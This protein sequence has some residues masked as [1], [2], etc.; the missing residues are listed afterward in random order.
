MARRRRIETLAGLTAT[1]FLLLL[2]VAVWLL[3]VAALV[4][5][6]VLLVMWLH[7]LFATRGLPHVAGRNAFSITHEEALEKQTHEARLHS[8]KNDLREVELRG[9]RLARTNGGKF[10][11]RSALGKELNIRV[12]AIEPKIQQLSEKIRQIDRLPAER[13]RKYFHAAS[14]FKAITIA[15]ICMQVVF[16]ILLVDQP[17]PLTDIASGVLQLVPLPISRWFA[18]TLC[19]MSVTGWCTYM[20]AS[21]VMTAKLASS[22]DNLPPCSTEEARRFSE[23]LAERFR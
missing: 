17:K 1:A 14:R 6:P 3:S 22:A 2:F 9:A 19:S 13:K 10:H 4:G 18:G 11:K 12:E 8:L 20:F 7:A 21:R 5:G 23:S 16:L 15:V